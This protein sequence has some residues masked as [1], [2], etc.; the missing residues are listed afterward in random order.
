M[1]DSQLINPKGSWVSATVVTPADPG[2]PAGRTP[3]P[4]ERIKPV[5]GGGIPANGNIVH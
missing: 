2:Y 1:A 5:E 4:A 3:L